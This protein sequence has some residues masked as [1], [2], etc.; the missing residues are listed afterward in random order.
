MLVLA[1]GVETSVEKAT[2]VLKVA[3]LSASQS[4]HIINCKFERQIGFK[5]NSFSGWVAHEKSIVDM[6]EVSIF[7]YH[8]ISIVSVFDLH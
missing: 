1:T 7:S 5:L 4:L 6:K 2:K 3:R 8:N